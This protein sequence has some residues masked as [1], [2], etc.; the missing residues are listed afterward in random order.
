M[1]AVDVFLAGAAFFA[2]AFLGAAAAFFAGAAF[3]GAADFAVVDFA[4]VDF[5]GAAFFA[6]AAFAAGLFAGAAFLVAAALV[7]VLFA[8]AF[9][10]AGAL[11]L[12]G[13]FVSGLFC[14]PD[15]YRQTQPRNRTVRAETH[16][17][18]RRPF[19][20]T[21]R[22]RRELHAPRGTWV[23][24]VTSRRSLGNDRGKLTLR[25]DEDTLVG[26]RLDG[27]AELGDLCVAD[28]ELV[29]VLD[30]P[31]WQKESGRDRADAAQRHT[32]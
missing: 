17:L 18:R 29:L 7:A 26:A 3:L 2:G 21:L 28:V 9:A 24:A 22:L 16:L 1:L 27:L 32:S 14:Q 31:E 20:G 15:Y 5:A 23:Y 6:V 25:Q 11:A 19:C 13:G 10:L 30:I 12:E 8:G 4:A